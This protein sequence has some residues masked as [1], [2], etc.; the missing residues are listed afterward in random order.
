MAF[1]KDKYP[2]LYNHLAQLAKHPDPYDGK[3]RPKPDP[4]PADMPVAAAGATGGAAQ[5]QA[6]VPQFGRRGRFRGG[7]VEPFFNAVYDA[8][9][10]VNGSDADLTMIDVKPGEAHNMNVLPGGNVAKPGAP[11]PIGFVAVL[12]KSDPAFHNGSGRLELAERIF[13][14]AA[15]LA[16]RVIVNRVWA[17]HFGKPLVATPSDFGAQGEKPTHPQLLDDL[18]A[19]F[20][21]NGWSLKWLH[22]QIML[23][24][25]YCQSSQ[26]R[27][28]ALK[29]D[30]AN[31]L[32]WRMNPRRLDVEAY[33]D[34][35]LQSAGLLD[36][37]MGGT[38]QD[39][40]QPFN[41]RRTVY[42]RISRARVN[43]L[44][45]LYDF[46]E[47]TMHSPSRQMTTTP[48]QQL[49]AMNSPFM[50]EMS[51]ALAKSV[52]NEA[53]APVRIRAMYRKILSREPSDAEL[54]RAVD[55][56]KSAN[57]TEVAHGLLCTNEVIFWP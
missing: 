35:L 39:L 10:W 46:P 26:P 33:R 2:Q 17:N 54:A 31:S 28:D 47:A 32:L 37:N 43:P 29:V 23:S 34:N 4:P 56:L 3:P 49:F 24:A 30:P 48:L 13:T 21:K 19:R 50:Q 52:E 40:D 41:H 42:A 9:L 6:Q 45:Q 38:S 57:L 18:A 11:A 12:A 20:V 1:L 15:P 14:D 5:N 16:A 53:D 36:R 22:R 55:Y 51:A 25:T 7:S 27:K 8:G 44:L